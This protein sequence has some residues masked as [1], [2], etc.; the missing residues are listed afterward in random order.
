MCFLLIYSAAIVNIFSNVS[1]YHFKIAIYNHIHTH[2]INSEF[3]TPY[4]VEMKKST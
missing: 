4:Y 3:R 1:L 2:T